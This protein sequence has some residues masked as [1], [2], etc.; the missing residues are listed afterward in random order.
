MKRIYT[1][2][3]KARRASGFHKEPTPSQQSQRRYVKRYELQ[4]KQPKTFGLQIV[5]HQRV[6]FKKD[7]FG[8]PVYKTINHAAT[9]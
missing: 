2:A 9:D 4:P 7:Q 1:L 6:R 5:R 8:A 3:K